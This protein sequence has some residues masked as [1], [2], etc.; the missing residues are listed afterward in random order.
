[1]ELICLRTTPN[2]DVRIHNFDF[3]IHLL[4]ASEGVVSLQKATYI[5]SNI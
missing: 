5:L 4:R 1:M 3:E 2:L